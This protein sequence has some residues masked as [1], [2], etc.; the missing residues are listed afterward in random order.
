MSSA[1]YAGSFDPITSGHLGIIRSGLIAFERLI[2]AVVANPSKHPL[3]TVDERMAMIREALADEPRVEVDRFEE[4]LLVDYARSRGVSVI[5][6]G[7]RALGDFEH[8]LQMANMNRHLAPGIATVFVMT[9]EHFFVSSSLVKEV[10]SLGGNLTGV[11]PGNVAAKLR[12]KFGRN[13]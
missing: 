11:V 5:L 13:A 9:D 2:V 10:A 12:E 6:K 1:I 8:E 4:G 3:F 7:L